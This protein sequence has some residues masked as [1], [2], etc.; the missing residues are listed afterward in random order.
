MRSPGE[1][2]LRLIDEASS[3]LDQIKLSVLN[4]V[5]LDRKAIS[6]IPTIEKILINIRN[7]SI[8]RDHLLGS[9]KTELSKKYKITQGRISTIIKKISTKQID[10]ER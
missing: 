7:M 8:Y 5:S 6:V 4:D 9:S 2:I 10:I 3:K 1:T